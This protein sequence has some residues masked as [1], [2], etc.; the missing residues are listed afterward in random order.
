MTMMISP[1]T[2]YEEYLRS[3]SQKEV[4]REIRS[5]KREINRLKAGHCHPCLL[6]GKQCIPV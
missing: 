1:E 4:L 3:K 5:L 2:Y 6:P